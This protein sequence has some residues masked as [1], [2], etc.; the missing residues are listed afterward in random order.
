[1]EASIELFKRLI[2]HDAEIQRIVVDYAEGNVSLA[3]GSVRVKPEGI[4]DGSLWSWPVLENV[5]LIFKNFGEI[6]VS[7]NEICQ[8]GVIYESLVR[9]IDPLEHTMDKSCL[10][11]YLFEITAMDGRLRIGADDFCLTSESLD[12]FT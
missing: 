5:L 2:L 3:I 1:M 6:T 4:T 11:K 7:F 8:S 10:R 9:D 12:Q